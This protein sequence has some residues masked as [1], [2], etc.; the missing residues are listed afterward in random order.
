MAQSAR[1]IVRID[2]WHLLSVL[3][4][5]ALDRSVMIL[6][7]I[8][9]LRARGTNVSAATAA[10]IFLVS[11]FVGSFLPAGVGGDAARAY[12]LSRVTAAG[13][14]ALASVIV[15]RVLGIVSLLTMGVVGLIAWTP[16]GGLDWRAGAAIVFVLLVCVATF[17]ADRFLSPLS[18]T[19]GYLHRVA[20]AISRYR[21]HRA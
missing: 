8:L 17:W 2:P 14:E 4:L 5:V 10:R 13:D 11:S 21:E 3:A 19:A 20:A 1:A 18:S 9:L 6:R 7:W 12:G 15:D 16:G